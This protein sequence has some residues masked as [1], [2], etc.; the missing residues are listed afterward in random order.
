MLGSCFV[1]KLKS[2]NLFAYSRVDLDITDKQALADV[3][4][5]V[6][7]DYVINCAAYTDVDACE[8]NEVV[9]FKVNGD[10]VK[11]MAVLCADIDAVLI[12]FSTDYVFDGMADGYDEDS[13]RFAI[14]AY[15][16]SK[17]AGEKSIE[18]KMKRYFIVRTS[19]LFGKNGGNFVDT[20][21]RLGEGVSVVGD[22][23]GS[24]TYVP[25][26]VDAVL[27]NLVEKKADFG[28]YHLTNSG[29]CSW[30][31]FAVEILGDNVKKIS[32]EEYKSPAKRPKCSILR[33]NKLGAL[34]DWR[35]A[36]K[37]YLSE[38]A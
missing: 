30:Y 27:E 14:T 21:L 6:R 23:F 1:E 16:E 38:K 13:Q 36:L 32:S 18:V 33:N 34:R 4:D 28:I 15:G 20:M 12:H 9:A 37:A 10:A 19:W 3:F 22:Q 24:P 17:L 25:D 8:S 31:E 7:P 2:H 11:Q 26:L 5:E 35:E 29:S